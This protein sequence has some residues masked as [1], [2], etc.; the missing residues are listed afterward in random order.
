MVHL[1]LSTFTAS[2]TDYDM[3]TLFSLHLFTSINSVI[4]QCDEG[5]KVAESGYFF[6]QAI[7]LLVLVYKKEYSCTKYGR[8]ACTKRDVALL[9]EFFHTFKKVS[10]VNRVNI[11]LLLNYQQSP[12]NLF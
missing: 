9:T 7:S 8:L 5:I 11:Y 6:D 12:K 2:E 4:G 1:R 3:H 10:R